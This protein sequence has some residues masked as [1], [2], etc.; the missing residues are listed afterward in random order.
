MKKVLNKFTGKEDYFLTWKEAAEH[1]GMSVGVLKYRHSKDCTLHQDFIPKISVYNNKL[2]FWLI[3]MDH[4]KNNYSHLIPKK[5]E[6]VSGKSETAE[7][8]ELSG[9]K[10]S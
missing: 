9:K 3:D 4:Y 1:I 10:R 6:K 8:F 2:G 5:R 7:V